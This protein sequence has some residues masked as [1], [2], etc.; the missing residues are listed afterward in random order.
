MPTYDFQCQQCGQRFE[1]RLSMADYSQGARPACP[2]CGDA[3]PLRAF[4]STI[5]VLTSRAR[6]QSPCAE[7]DG[8]CRAEDEGACGAGA[9]GCLGPYDASC[10]LA[11]GVA[12]SRHVERPRDGARQRPRPS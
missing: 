8:S 10:V 9:C 2:A 1:R 12:P 6:P 4:T 5:N 7:P 3:A 11:N